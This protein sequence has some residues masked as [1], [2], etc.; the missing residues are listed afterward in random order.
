MIDRG[1]GNTLR[2][3]REGGPVGLHEALQGA[4]VRLGSALVVDASAPSSAWARVARGGR[5]ADV[6]SS[7]DKRS[8]SV[9]LWLHGVTFAHGWASRLADVA[10]VVHA[11]LQGGASASA[12]HE[13]FSWLSVSPLAFVHESGATA[14]VDHAWSRL[15]AE[16]DKD[17]AERVRWLAPLVKAC[18]DRPRLRALMPYVAHSA[19]CL[20]RTT[21]APF[22][23][24]CPLVH[25]VE[26]EKFRLEGTPVREG[27]AESVAV[28]LE[29]LIAKDCTA[30]QHGTAEERVGED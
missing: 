1:H 12:L 21:G 19:F 15:A 22:T 14:Y 29:S 30:A 26:E 24:E 11:F 4:L 18:A 3:E 27:D 20:S 2:V 16:V 13:G 23:R 10:T 7:L 17:G 8:F 6:A 25:A 9:D 5:S 28:L